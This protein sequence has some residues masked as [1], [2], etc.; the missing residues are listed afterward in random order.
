MFIV[1]AAIGKNNEIGK[2][3][4]LLW[5]I[6]EDLKNF[7]EITYGKT[8]VMGRKTYESIGKPLPNRKN[9][10]LTRNHSISDDK[11]IEIHYD[12][13][14]FINIYKDNREEIFII[15]GEE[16][17]RE[18]L[19][20]NLIEKMYISHVDFQCEDADAYFPNIDYKKWNKE[21]EKQHD[22]WKLCIYKIK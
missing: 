18:F 7:K 9:I 11:N 12:L 5:H 8:I 3:N 14:N 19:K 13:E 6:P 4:K 21:L 20:R 10:I 16:I 15:G 1:I 17:Y 2:E 22:G